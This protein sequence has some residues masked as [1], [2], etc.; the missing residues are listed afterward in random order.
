MTEIRKVVIVGAGYIAHAVHIP[1]WKRIEGVEVLG[2]FDVNQ[3]RASKVA[4]EHRIARI[5]K[6]CGEALVEPSVD[7]VDICTPPSTHAEL[8]LKALESGHNVLVEKPLAINYA[9][10]QRVV[11]LATSRNLKI[12]V[13]QHYVY[14][15]AIQEA[16]KR[17]TSGEIGKLLSI[18]V[19]YPIGRANPSL[20]S[21]RPS[22]G[23]LLFELGPHPIYTALYLL[24]CPDEIEAFGNLPTT[25]QHCFG[26]I[27][28]R[29][30]ST[31]ALIH[32]SHNP[33]YNYR[34]RIHCE[35]KSLMVDL[36][37]DSIISLDNFKS[38]TSQTKFASSYFLSATKEYRS[39]ASGFAK[40]TL[41]FLLKPQK[42]INQFRL[43]ADYVSWLEGKSD[44][45]SGPDLGLTTVKILSIAQNCL[46]DDAS[47]FRRAPTLPTNSALMASMPPQKKS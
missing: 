34:V 3:D 11:N 30:G 12:G 21:S 46:F 24:G 9:D 17:I 31:T 35:F 36:V 38:F 28:L 1:C 22:E 25:T 15:R 39:L 20:W 6:T 26:S 29:R 5:Y 27:L 37:S 32:L 8:A 13:V 7:V 14:S 18:E 44:F 40:K 33:S 19:F 2:I 10:A 43:L 47:V 45:Q 41:A 4:H 23:G 42:E 16:K